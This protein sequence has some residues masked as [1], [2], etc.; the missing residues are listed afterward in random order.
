M[1]QQKMYLSVFLLYFLITVVVDSFLLDSAKSIKPSLRTEEVKKIVLHCQLLGMNCRN[2]TDFSF[3]F[4]GFSLRG[5]STDIHCHGWGLAIYEGRGLRMFHDPEACASSPIANLVA[6]LNIKTHNL[7]AHIRWAT[8]GEVCLAN[9]HPFQRELYGIQWT[10]AHNGD[11]PLFKSE[12]GTELPWIGKGVT[13]D[14][15]YN[16]VGDTDSEKIFCSILNA[17]RAKFETLPEIDTL[18][19]YLV[20]LLDEIVEHDP[21]G[22]ILNFILACG[23]QYQFAYSWPGKRPGSKVWNG[24]YYVVR[25]PPFKRTSLI[26]CD[27]EVDFAQLA[28]EDDRVSVVATKPLT[29]NEEWIEFERGQLILFDSGTPKVADSGCNGLHCLHEDQRRFN[30]TESST[31]SSFLGSCI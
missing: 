25:E 20:E 5:G 22:S 10:F 7:I 11:V 8:Q 28:G 19:Q 23:N 31:I 21:E 6:N 17:L 16:P 18:Y 12:E 15:A 27:Y 1:K 4:K 2:P 9:V 24:L 30:Q 26:D 13:G 29:H 3:S 14:K